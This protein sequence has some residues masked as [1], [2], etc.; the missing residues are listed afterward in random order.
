MDEALYCK[1]HQHCDLHDLLLNM[2]PYELIYIEPTDTYWGNGA[3]TGLNKFGKLLVH[4]R[5]HLRSK[6]GM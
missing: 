2:Y 6:V 1:F 4:V 3:G 5:N